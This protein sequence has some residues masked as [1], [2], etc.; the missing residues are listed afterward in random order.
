MKIEDEELFFAI[1]KL[2]AK[3]WQNYGI[4]IRAEDNKRGRLT[5]LWSCLLPN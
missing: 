5:V 1:G 4:A 2:I 3:L